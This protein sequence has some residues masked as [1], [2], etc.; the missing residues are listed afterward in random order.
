LVIPARSGN[1]DGMTGMNPPK[2]GAKAPVSAIFV[3]VVVFVAF[4]LLYALVLIL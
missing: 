2:G 3:L 4:F 1:P